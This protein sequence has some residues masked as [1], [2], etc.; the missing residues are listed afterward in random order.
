MNQEVLQ[1]WLGALRSGDYEQ[2]HGALR[3]NAKFCCLGV[4]CDLHKDAADDGGVGW[5]RPEFTETWY[6]GDN[7]IELSDKVMEWAGLG[8]RNPA[9]TRSAV[10]QVLGRELAATELRD[11]DQNAAGLNDELRM[12]LP[13]IADVLEACYG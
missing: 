8:E 1:Q 5:Y 6:Y 10:E 3:S 2:G 13:G 12:T 11:G 4:L 7:P 9:V